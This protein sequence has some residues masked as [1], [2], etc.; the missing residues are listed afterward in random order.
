MVVCSIPVLLGTGGGLLLAPTNPNIP[1]DRPE[2]IMEA[3]K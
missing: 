3:D 2:V 1:A